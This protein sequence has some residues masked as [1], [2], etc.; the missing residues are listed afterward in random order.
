MLD[1]DWEGTLSHPI[2]ITKFS[3]KLM[4]AI[5]IPLPPEIIPPYQEYL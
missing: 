2:F 1:L 4:Y 5:L 3:Q